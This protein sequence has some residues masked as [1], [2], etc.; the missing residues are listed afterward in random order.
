MIVVPHIMTKGDL[1]NPRFRA[2]IISLALTLVFFAPLA[3]AFDTD[4][5]GFDDSVDDCPVAFGN[6]TVDRD[7]C[8]D[9]DGDGTSDF[10]DPW[11]IQAGGF[12]EDNRQ[13]MSDDQSVSLFN[14]DGS[15]YLTVE[16]TGGWGSSNGWLR[17][18]DTATKVNVKSVEFSGD[19][20]RDADWSPDGMFIAAITDDEELFAYYSSNV[21][22]FFSV[23][24]GNGEQANEVAYSPD[25]T[26]IAV[27][28]SRSGNSGSGEVQIYNSLNGSEITSFNPNSEINFYSVDW[29]P[30]SSRILIGGSEDVW[31]YNTGSWNVNRTINT[32]R[33]T[34][35]AVAWSPDGITIA[36]CE[37]YESSGAR[38]RLYD[39]A[40]G[41]E[42]WVYDTSTSC[43]DVEYSPDGTQVFAAH[44]YYQSD[45]ASLKVFKVDASSATI[46]DTMS[47]PRPGGCTS[48]QSG[49]N[50]GSIYGV[51]WHPDGDYIL[52]AHGRNDEGIYHWIV[53][54]DIDND[55]VLNADDA[56]PEEPTQWN[57]TDNDG[58]GDNPA[59][60]NEPDECPN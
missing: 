24:L 9:R 47:A 34:N 45:G 11:V 5:D 58:F 12:L 26:M 29:S 51:S 13:S 55:G 20:I 17:I 21:T 46:V 28:I 43:L 56:F 23:S 59:P 42:N 31:I 44:H 14:H 33:G 57:D 3:S 52:S 18:W 4:G 7:G 60:A 36:T 50:C 10:A 54:P 8:P 41:L 19:E 15:K 48:G 2:I 1:A 49:N 30:D 6:S 39:V 22:P 27:V 40:S 32:N 25:G 37:A 38:V 53:N 35:N 16:D